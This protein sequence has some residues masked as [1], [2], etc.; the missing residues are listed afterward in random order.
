M[1]AY[2]AEQ[3][4]NAIFDDGVWRIF[5]KYTLAIVSSEM[6]RSA[7]VAVTGAGTA[8]LLY[9]GA[10]RVFSG[11]LT[12]GG[13]MTFAVTLSLLM[14]PV[15]QLVGLAA[16]MP[17]AIARVE[18]ALALL[19]EQ[20][21]SSLHDRPTIMPTL[22]GAVRFEQVS[23]GYAPGRLVLRDVS[24]EVAPGQV[25]AIIGASGAGKS[26]I[27]ALIASLYT[28]SAGRVIVDG[29]DL[30]TVSFTWSRSQLGMVLQDTFLF[31]GTVLENVAYAQLGATDAEIVAACRA[32]HVD[33]F[34]ASLPDGYQS[35]IGERGVRL[36]G[37]QRQR[38]A[39]ARAL[40]AR[41]QILILDEPT[42]SLDPYGE[43]LV[44]DALLALIQ[45]R[46]TF[47]ISHRPSL[48]RVADRVL[49]VDHGRV[50]EGSFEET[51]SQ[52]GMRPTRGDAGASKRWALVPRAFGET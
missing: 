32:A 35:R 10:L 33:E 21:E 52:M 12:L 49:I 37:G 31:D 48:L 1:K 2:G 6:V 13:L 23:F 24:F 30:S 9:L 51:L 22:R 28:P 36:S 25:M 40:L 42:S 7:S 47:L 16:E 34:V 8:A 18:R 46:T 38:I 20:P 41:P 14:A 29:V 50:H 43:T 44:V 27:A 4:E 39:I 5:Q 26:T 19:A 3:H 11:E 15:T 17:E 45:G